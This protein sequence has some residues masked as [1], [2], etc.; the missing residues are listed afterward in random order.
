MLVVVKQ[1]AVKLEEF[2]TTEARAHLRAGIIASLSVLYLVTFPILQAPLLVCV[3]V[4]LTAWSYDRRRGLHASLLAF[5]LNLVLIEWFTERSIWR[6]LPDLGNG[7]LTGHIVMILLSLGIGAARESLEE[8]FQ[9]KQRLL[10]QERFIGL[11]NII[12]KKILAPSR[13]DRLYDDIINHLTNLFVADYGLITRWE[14]VEE[15]SL[16]VATTHASR[17]TY[18]GREL[19]AHESQLAAQVL[20]TG[21]VLVIED[22]QNT[23]YRLSPIGTRQVR[24]AICLPLVAREYKFGTALLAY[25]QPRR[26]TGEDVAQAERVGHQIALALWTVRQDEISQRQLNET[27]TLM[28]IGQT[29]S[30]TER[31]G[32]NVVLQSIVDSARTL[33]SQAE[34]SVIHLLDKDTQSLVPQATSGFRE[35]EKRISN[36]RMHIGAGAAG[37]VLRDGITINIADV[38]TDDRFLQ[39]ERKPAY[40]S[41]L[42]APVQ[43][44]GRQLGTISVE[45]EKVNAFSEHEA[46]LLKALG[47]QAAIAIENTRLFESTQ[48]SLRE[49]NALYAISQGLAASLDTDQLIQDVLDILQQNFGYFYIQIFLLDP[50]TGDLV[51]QRGTGK[52]GAKLSEQG[53]RLSPGQ[54]ISGYVAA[55]ESP[56]VT[57]HADDI[58]FFHRHPLLPD[59]RSELAVPIKVE[60]RVVGVLDIQHVPPHHLSEEDLRLMSAVADQ[61]A[62]ALQKANLYSNL[63]AALQQEQA[64]RSQLLQSERLALV[65]RLLASVSHELNN[66]LQAIQNALFLLKEETTLSPQGKQDLGIVLSETER[67]AML[68]ERLRSAYRP[69]RMNDLQSVHLNTLV[70]DVYALIATHM[71]HRQ[72]AFE[73]LPEADLPMISGIS[74]QI[75][76]VILNLFL[77]AIEIMSP[78]GCLVVQT[79]ALPLQ[80]EVQLSVRDSGPGIDEEILPDIF[81][82]FITGKPT[83][84]G[85]GLT[86]TRDIIQQHR[87]RIE[88]QN[89]P[90]GGAV[91]TLWLPIHQGTSS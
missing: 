28:Q 29:L 86:I 20:E 68:I 89:H 57:N 65:G 83:G 91:F 18:A 4:F 62:V 9:L 44:A 27:R 63:Q 75:R 7:F 17:D 43:T 55:T 22:L 59:T 61:L 21:Q 56:F 41:L 13:P 37:Q 14:A 26:Y 77:N 50:E 40:R 81:E 76:Q 49:V 79:H 6:V 70:E 45:S 36:L 54:G 52:I 87:G 8:I 90:E 10:S 38:L 42:V 23:P 64:M 66:P 58:A 5:L 39:M 32:L 1:A 82:P 25:D 73:F 80:N 84:T 48:Q 46:E 60:G 15:K 11:S 35:A 31:V 72:V 67:M 53:Y 33:I 24:S 88:A 2:V 74:D 30:E 16:I 3:P 51:F 19:P 12:V 85:L 71:R 47:N 34:K 69:A 78:G